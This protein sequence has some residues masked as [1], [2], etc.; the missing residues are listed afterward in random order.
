[1]FELTVQIEAQPLQIGPKRPTLYLVFLV[2]VIVI[3]GLSEEILKWHSHSLSAEL[4]IIF[5]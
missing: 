5:L 1:M 3:A 2:I 4:W